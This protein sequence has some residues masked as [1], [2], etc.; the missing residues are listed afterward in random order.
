MNNVGKTYAVVFIIDTVAA[1]DRFGVIAEIN[2][3]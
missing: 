1:I 3:W 2:L